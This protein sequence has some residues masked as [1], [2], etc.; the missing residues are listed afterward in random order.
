MKSLLFYCLE[1][2]RPDLLPCFS[3]ENSSIPRN[4]LGDEI[5][6]MI[7]CELLESGFHNQ[8][9]NEHGRKLDQLISKIDQQIHMLSCR[10]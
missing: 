8:L 9:L 10:Q 5:R 4:E 6:D 3:G 7:I 1:K 2:R